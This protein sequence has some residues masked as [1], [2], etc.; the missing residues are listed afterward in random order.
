MTWLWTG[1]ALVEAMDGRPLGTMPEG[2]TGLS[3][4]SRTIA[5]GEAF[6]AIRGERFDG[7]D[8]ASAALANGAGLLV[9]S[10]A[11]LPALG[12]LQVPMIIV[13]DVLEALGRLAIAARARS[14][15]T[16]IAVTGS[17]GKTTTKEMLRRALEP[18]GSVHV[19]PASFNNHWGVP[20]SLARMPAETRFAVFELG[21]NHAGEIG[22]LS[23]LVRPHIAI[24]TT[25]AAAHLGNFD[26][27]NGIAFAKA[28]IFEGLEPDG[29]AVLNRDN[30]K[31]SLLKKAAVKA[32]CAHV[33]GFGEHKRAE[34][35]LLNIEL[36]PD[37]SCLT[38]RIGTQDVA[39]KISAPGRHLAQN[40]LATL[41]AV[42]LAGADLAKAAL[43]FSSIMPEKGRGE[44]HLLELDGSP[45][46]LIDESYNANPASMR[47]ALE[48]LR[49]TPVSL[50]GRRIAILGDMLELGRFSRDYHAGLA[51]PLQEAGVE[52]L[53]LAGDEMRA[54]HDCVRGKMSVDHRANAEE[55]AEII[56]RTIQPGDAVMVK[57]S[58]GLGFSKIVQALMDRYASRA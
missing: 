48:N 58:N 23:R 27:L 34:F 13:D 32:G 40:A 45:F 17:A 5:A 49:D 44:R 36:L 31:F 33:H 53:L 35:R 43:S 2:V 39:L 4:D 7:H 20:L 41:G 24:I 6:F 28:E 8:F 21:M 11:R 55:L 51:E 10:E 47:A 52:V 3:I 15:A 57:S 19:S 18:S 42:H 9:V 46:T 50:R 25:I 26:S 12:R 22:P 30:E 29:H 38:A 1:D 16:V 14:R 54:L 56:V 37:C